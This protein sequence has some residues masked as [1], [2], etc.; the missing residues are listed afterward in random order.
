VSASFWIDQPRDAFTKVCRSQFGQGF[1][2]T[3][4]EVVPVRVIKER[5]VYADVIDSRINQINRAKNQHKG[6]DFSRSRRAMRNT[7]LIQLSEEK[8]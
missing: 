7:T 2:D 8:G 3:T 4:A 5:P 6:A 1:P